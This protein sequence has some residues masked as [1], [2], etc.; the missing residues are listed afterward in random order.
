MDNQIFKKL[1]VKPG[2]SASVL[3]AP[4][5]YPFAQSALSFDKASAQFDFVHLFVTS[6][7]EFEQRINEALSQ[8]KTGGLLWVSYPKGSG[9]IK[10]D[11]NRDSLWDLAIPHDIHPVSQVSLDDTWSAVRFVD[12]KPGEVY[13][14]PKKA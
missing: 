11:I 12:N 1:R 10:A 3:Y 9:K 5:N 13:E 7:Q 4:E 8:R 2:Q 6:R 14:R